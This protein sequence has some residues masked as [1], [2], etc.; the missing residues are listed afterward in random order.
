MNVTTATATSTAA[1][2]MFRSDFG[3]EEYVPVSAG[4]ASVTLDTFGATNGDHWL[5]LPTAVLRTTATTGG[6]PAQQR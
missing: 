6:T 5:W 2:V 1:A 3:F 4:S